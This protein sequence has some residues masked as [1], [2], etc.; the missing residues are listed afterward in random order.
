VYL[1]LLGFFFFFAIVASFCRTFVRLLTL[2]YIY[3]YLVLCVQVIVDQPEQPSTDQQQQTGTS[4][5][6][7][8]ADMVAAG[9][10]TPDEEG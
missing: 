3:M 6:P 8:D 4:Q 2:D 7:A 9:H 5:Q 10:S 1:F